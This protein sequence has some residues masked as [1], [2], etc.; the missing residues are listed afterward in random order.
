MQ[1]Q[2]EK[3]RQYPCAEFI[4]KFLTQSI[5]IMQ[6]IYR[7]KEYDVFVGGDIVCR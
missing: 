6:K 5:E 4:N 1:I 2:V 3:I 7:Q